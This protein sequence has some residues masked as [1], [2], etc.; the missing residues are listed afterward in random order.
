MAQD[1]T[2]TERMEAYRGSF[3]LTGMTVLV[4]GGPSRD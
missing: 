3:D 2:I 1:Q 4:L